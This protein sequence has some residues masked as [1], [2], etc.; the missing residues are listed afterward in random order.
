MLHSSNTWTG[1]EVPYT[2]GPLSALG[3]RGSSSLLHVAST[4]NSADRLLG[5][6]APDSPPGK[7]SHNS[8]PLL[9]RH[10]AF[11]RRYRV[12]WCAALFLRHEAAQGCSKCKSEI[13]EAKD[14]WDYETE[15]YSR[16]AIMQMQ[17]EPHCQDRISR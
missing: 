8:Y 11:V 1:H 17:G 16:W 6:T 12:G 15:G 7:V 2:Y 3:H 9:R 14:L 5:C 13:E 4:D 10:Y